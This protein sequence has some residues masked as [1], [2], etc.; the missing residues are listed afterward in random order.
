MPYEKFPVYD[1]PQ[2]TL[3]IWQRKLEYLLNKNLNSDNIASTGLTLGTGQVKASNI[4]FGTG[5]NQVDAA[6]ILIVDNSSYFSSLNIETALQEFYS[7]YSTHK[8]S[9]AIHLESTTITTV[10]QINSTN[11]LITDNSSYFTGTNI[12][13]AL[14]EFY[15]TYSTH[16]DSTSIHLRST[17]ITTLVPI[18]STSIVYTPSTAFSVLSTALTGTT[19]LTNPVALNSD[20]IQT[21]DKV[22]LIRQRLI[23]VGILTT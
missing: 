14:Q 22:N 5:A 21:N 11:V 7:T 16:R 17:S 15:S 23:D 13:S 19:E 10:I 20:L 12:E 4:D 2:Q 9:T 6:D 18:N 1:D 8:N 3:K